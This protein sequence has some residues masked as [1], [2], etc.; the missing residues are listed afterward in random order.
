M[1]DT[2]QTADPLR[3]RLAALKGAEYFDDVPD[4]TGTDRHRWLTITI[5]AARRVL[6]VRIRDLSAMR[7]V[8]TFE[9]AVREAFAAADGARLLASLERHGL[10]DEYLERARA[11]LAGLRP[12]VAPPRP[13]VSRKACR[14]RAAARARGDVRRRPRR[15]DPV[16]SDNGYLTVQ[17]A[18]DG[19]LVALDVDAVWLSGVRE[20]HLRQALLEALRFEAS[21]PIGEAV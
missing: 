15:P 6:D 19:G 11:T 5:D 8:D 18:A 12:V 14:E 16:T 7:A 3:A 13:D 9:D 1:T 17:R 20:E 21:E 10:A 4:T 2:D